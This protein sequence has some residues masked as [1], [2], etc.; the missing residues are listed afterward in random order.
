M[1]NN[2]SEIWLKDQAKIEFLCALISGLSL[3]ERNLTLSALDY[4]SLGLSK[5]HQIEAAIDRAVNLGKII[6]DLIRVLKKTSFDC[7][8][9]KGY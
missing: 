2:K 3:S 6:D 7:Q 4:Q 5:K 9:D 1:E 8:L